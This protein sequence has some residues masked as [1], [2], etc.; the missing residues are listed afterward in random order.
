LSYIG[1]DALLYH[2]VDGRLLGLA[3]MLAKIIE[4]SPTIIENSGEG[5]ARTAEV[6]RSKREQHELQDAL[7]SLLV[8][9]PDGR[10]VWKAPNAMAQ[11][12]VSDHVL[13][14]VRLGKPVFETTET[15]DGKPVRHVF[16]A[17]PQQGPVRYVLQAETSMIL[18]RATR[19]GLVILLTI[20]SGVI[21]FVAWLGSEWLA[22][23]VLT[24]IEVLSAGAER[25]RNPT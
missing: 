21:L 11:Q 18:H 15:T 19:N 20:G 13:D 5:V 4:Q 22:K 9:S 23:K 1:N 10:L 7:L 25:C 17:I 8:F 2:F 14:Q 12:P 24:P 3:E 16:I 6:G